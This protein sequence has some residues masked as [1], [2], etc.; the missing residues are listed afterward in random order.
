L[1]HC[2]KGIS[3]ENEQT[4]VALGEMLSRCENLADLDISGKSFMRIFILC[5]SGIDLT[6]EAS[7]D[8]GD[9]L[10]KNTSL[11]TLAIYGKINFAFFSSAVPRY[12]LFIPPSYWFLSLSPAALSHLFLR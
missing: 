1:S 11:R 8:L 4:L 7:K 9:A 6:Q 10:K 3:A 2:N 5:H 12:L